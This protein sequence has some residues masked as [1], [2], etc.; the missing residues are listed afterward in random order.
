MREINNKITTDFLFTKPSFW[1]GFARI[2]DLF[3]TF[4]DF[5]TSSSDEEADVKAILNDWAMVGQD[6]EKCFNYPQEK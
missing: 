3:G 6:L 4:D 5:N 1:T 2:F